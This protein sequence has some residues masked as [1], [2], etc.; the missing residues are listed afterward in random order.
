MLQNEDKCKIYSLFGLS[1]PLPLPLPLPLLFLSLLL[2]LLVLVVFS[3]FLLLLLLVLFL[4]LFAMFLFL[5]ISLVSLR[6]FWT[7]CMFGSG[8]RGRSRPLAAWGPGAST[9]PWCWS[10]SRAGL[11]R[12]D[13]RVEV[14]LFSGWNLV[15]LSGKISTIVLGGGWSR[16]NSNI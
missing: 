8:L 16:Q 10:S 12:S 15:S 11:V 4:A 2:T 3:L 1:R 13:S 6:T 9:S 14:W 5:I 7:N